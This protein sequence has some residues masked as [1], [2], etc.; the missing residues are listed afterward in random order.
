MHARLVFDGSTGTLD[1]FSK[2]LDTLHCPLFRYDDVLLCY[3]ELVG[4]NW[5]VPDPE[6]RL[7]PPIPSQSE[8]TDQPRSAVSSP[9]SSE[10]LDS[11]QTVVPVRSRLWSRD[12]DNAL[13]AGIEQFGWAKWDEIQRTDPVLRNRTPR[14]LRE[15]ALRLQT[16]VP[17]RPSLWSRDEDSA[18]VAGLEQFGWGK[19]EDIQRTEPVL[20]NRTPRAILERAVS[21]SLRRKYHARHFSAE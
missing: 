4:K 1:S 14:A 20:R 18:L 16:V 9:Q 21:L 15:R 11:L 19:W 2:F 10:S 13:V 12:E 5:E 3:S 7:G 6:V 8:V 17:V